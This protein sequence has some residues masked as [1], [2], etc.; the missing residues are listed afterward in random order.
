MMGIVNQR[1][2]DFSIDTE[3]KVFI[4]KGYKSQIREKPC[5]CWADF[6]D[7]H[8]FVWPCEKHEL[9]NDKIL[10]KEINRDWE[11]Q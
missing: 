3:E 4:K 9:E 5:G 10:L 1:F 6:M 11:K 2:T 7:Y 8:I